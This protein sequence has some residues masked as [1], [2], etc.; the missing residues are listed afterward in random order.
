MFIRK[1]I[2]DTDIQL[3]IGNIKKTKTTTQSPPFVESSCTTKDGYQ[4]KQS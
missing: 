2:K 3:K 4:L 1:Q